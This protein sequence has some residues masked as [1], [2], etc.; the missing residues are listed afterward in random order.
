[1]QFSNR[2]QFQKF[3]SGR[4]GV[5]SIEYALLISLIAVAVIGALLLFGDELGQLFDKI[6]GAGPGSADL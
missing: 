1:M 4:A 6:A 2:H 3:V 5:T